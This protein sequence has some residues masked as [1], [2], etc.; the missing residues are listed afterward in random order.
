MC[1][2]LSNMFFPRTLNPTS[3]ILVEVAKWRRKKKTQRWPK[4]QN[5]KFLQEPRNK[6][7]VTRS[8]QTVTRFLMFVNILVT[9]VSKRASSDLSF[10][11]ASHG[12]ACGQ[13]YCPWNAMA[14]TF[15][16]EP[17]I[18]H[19]TFGLKIGHCITELLDPLAWFSPSGSRALPKALNAVIT[20][21]HWTRNHNCVVLRKCARLAHLTAKNETT[22]W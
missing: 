10:V 13:R 20:N 17:W 9:T 16:I 5:S 14:R 2:C 4:S 1:P 6:Q 15:S 8:K 3:R 22:C 11:C 18:E 7:T 19:T 21:L 12:G